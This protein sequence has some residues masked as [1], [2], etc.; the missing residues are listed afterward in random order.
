MILKRSISTPPP[1][2]T[3]LV[4]LLLRCSKLLPIQPF[5]ILLYF[6]IWSLLLSLM[7]PWMALLMI[8]LRMS[9]LRYAFLIVSALYFLQLAFHLSTY[10]YWHDSHC[11]SLCPSELPKA[12]PFQRRGSKL[13]GSKNYIF[14]ARV[15]WVCFIQ[16]GKMSGR[17]SYPC[18]RQYHPHPPYPLHTHHL[19]QSFFNISYEVELKYGYFFWNLCIFIIYIVQVWGELVWRRRV[20]MEQGGLVFIPTI[21]SYPYAYPTELG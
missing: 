8:C 5:P 15:S 11:C 21:F 16:D 18:L 12:F 3:D 20:D 1:E 19:A 10:I 13:K 9:L 6:L 2:R 17:V 4:V 14:V 7:A